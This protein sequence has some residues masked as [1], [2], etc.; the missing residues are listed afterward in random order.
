MALSGEVDLLGEFL[1][2]GELWYAGVVAEQVGALRRAKCKALVVHQ[3]LVKMYQDECA[4]QGA[5]I[6]VHGVKNLID[7]GKMVQGWEDW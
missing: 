3:E 5:R 6:Q 4:K 2:L 1:G 7:L